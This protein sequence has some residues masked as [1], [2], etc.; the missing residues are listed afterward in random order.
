MSILGKLV[1][2]L[3]YH[4]RN[5]KAYINKFG[6]HQN[7]MRMLAAEREMRDYAL[8]D[9]VIDAALNPEGKFKI[10]FLTGD[11]FIHQTLFCTYSFFRFLDRDETANF[12]VN[13][14]SDGTLS[15]E[16]VSILG[17]RFPT[18]RIINSI[19]TDKTLTDHLPQ[20]KFP[21]LNKNVRRFPLFKK[22]IYPNLNSEGL[23]VFF[24]SDMLFLRRPSELLNWIYQS[25]RNTDRAFCIQDVQRSYGYSDEEI[26]HVWP[27][28]IEHNINSGLYALHSKNLDWSFFE[29]LSQKFELS[30]GPHYYM[31]QLMTAIMLERSPDLFVAP[32]SD[33][34]VFP[35]KEQVAD[36]AGTLHHYVNESKEY[37]FKEGWRHQIR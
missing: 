36:Q 17:K 1:Y 33:Y 27:K 18:I 34:I 24:D 22:L 19:E 4:P 29:T 31:E 7:Y 25:E 6:G 14:Y 23:L 16:L 37:Y 20:S 26:A 5:K 8:N 28:A 13:Y 3:Y 10:N 15:P 12:S 21:Y 2:K 32:K 11:K 9:L 35:S 30:Y